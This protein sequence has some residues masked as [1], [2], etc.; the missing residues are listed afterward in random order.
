M[1]LCMTKGTK[2][3]QWGKD[4]YSWQ[5][6]HEK[7]STALILGKMQIKTI[8]PIHI[9]WDAVIKWNKPEKQ[10]GFLRMWKHGHP[11][12][13]V[14]LWK[15]V[16]WVFKK[17]KGRI[18]I[19]SNNSTSGYTPKRTESKDSERYLYTSVHWSIIYDSLKVE[20]LQYLLI[21]EWINQMYSTHT[22]E[23]YSA[24]KRN[25][26]LIHVRT[27]VSL[28]YYAYPLEYGLYLCIMKTMLS[29]INRLQKYN[30]CMILHT[31]GT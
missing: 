15:P 31:W 30:Q 2:T 25:E 5:Q 21:D 27:W 9:C 8:N 1:N 17:I 16:W 23:Y 11:C 4:I 26:I 7:C 24:L 3:V 12:A 22:M 6:A 29:E 18:I 13:L 10:Q 14:G 20:K 19:W 28:I